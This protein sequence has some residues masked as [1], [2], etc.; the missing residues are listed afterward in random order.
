[1]AFFG[2]DYVAPY[3]GAWIETSFP[4]SDGLFPLS[5]PTRERGLK[6]NMSYNQYKNTFVA[7]YAGAWIET[8]QDCRPLSKIASLPTRERGLKQAEMRKSSQSG[9]SLPTRERGLK[10][11]ICSGTRLPSEVAPYAGAW[12]E[13][14]HIKNKI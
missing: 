3:A 11:P 12:I 10:L 6:L 9:K 14:H 8:R 13:T 1:M 5:L 7:P 4:L 2:E